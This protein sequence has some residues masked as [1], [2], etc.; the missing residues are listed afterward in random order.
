MHPL[1]ARPSLL[2]A[3]LAIVV[4]AGAYLYLQGQE[5]ADERR[6]HPGTRP[7]AGRDAR[8]R[9]PRTADGRSTWRCS[10]SRSRRCTPSRSKTL[11]AIEGMFADATIRMGEQI[12]SLDLTERPSGGG[13][14]EL[15]PDG[16][17]AFS[18]GVSDTMAA[19]G[20]VK[21]GDRLDLIAVFQEQKAGRDGSVVVVQNVE[22]LAIS[23]VL[24]GE[25]QSDDEEG[26]GGGTSPTSIS[27][28]VTVA[29]EPSDAQRVAL[30][31]EFG[32]IRLALRRADD[33][34]ELLAPS[35]DLSDV[36][37]FTSGGG[38]AFGG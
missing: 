34:S 13:L 37:G 16:Y 23:R 29:L 30:A 21:P 6:H 38:T 15:I 10:A 9:A 33:A 24:L 25:A 28:T 2:G 11:D 5:D 17:R 36:S 14:A 7:R 1:L 20:L 3:V 26:A 22:V 32:S 4:G 19:G 27:A 18:I 8:D 35:I 31:D 12:L